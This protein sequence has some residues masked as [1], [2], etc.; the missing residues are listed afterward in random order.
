MVNG[1]Q[2][3]RWLERSARR[4]RPSAAVC[5]LPTCTGSESRWTRYWPKRDGVVLQ[6][7]Y[8]CRRQCLETALAA[9]LA[10]LHAVAPAVPPSN[11]IPLGLLM[12]ARGWLTHQQV[13]EALAA[14]Q[15]AHSGQIGDWFETLGFATERQVTSA[16]ALQWGCPVATSLEAAALQPFDQI[17]LGILEAFQMLPLHFEPATNT[18]Y[19]AFGQ[20]VDHAALYAIEKILGCRTQPCVG[21]R[22]HI[23]DELIRMRQ[24]PRPRE[25]EFGSM[26]EFADIGRVSV[27]YMVRLGADEARVGRVGDFIWLRLRARNVNTDVVFLL[28]ATVAIK[29]GALEMKHPETRVARTGSR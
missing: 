14:Q 8:Y 22:R 17:P 1:E 24:Q 19:I 29:N 7:V 13:V 9:Q 15:S 27:S 16:L 23:A 2:I 6:G 11:R 4:L 18:I 25:I 28:K 20:R 10:R 12:V 5:G 21:G 3:L 26:R